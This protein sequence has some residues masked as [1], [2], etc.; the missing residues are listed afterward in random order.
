MRDRQTDLLLF[1]R[2]FFFF[3]P[4]PFFPFPF[5]FPFFLEL[6]IFCSDPFVHYK[7][8]PQ[9][10]KTCHTSYAHGRS[11]G[12]TSNGQKNQA[13]DPIPCLLGY[14]TTS[15]RARGNAA[16]YFC[17]THLLGWWVV[18]CSCKTPVSQLVLAWKIA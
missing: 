7:A 3:F 1:L 2:V 11:N 16:G 17:R 5:P 10:K 12:V 6:S 13:L 4:F 9:K 18:V 15:T 14:A 8:Q